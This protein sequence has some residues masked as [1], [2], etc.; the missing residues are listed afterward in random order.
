MIRYD[1]R[2]AN[3]DEFEGWE[4][5]APTLP[6]NGRDDVGMKEEWV[7]AIKGGPAAYS[8]FDFAADMTEAILLG[9]LAIRAGG[10]VEWNSERL[11]AGSR[12]AQKFVKRDYR[13]GWKMPR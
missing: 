13:K 11:R 1:L 10:R 7:A 2:C 8:N 6:R 9:N 3:G 4:D 12:D 5:P